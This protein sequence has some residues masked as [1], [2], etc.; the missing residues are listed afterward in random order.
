MIKDINLV[1][2]TLI[3]KEAIEYLLEMERIGGKLLSSEREHKYLT[4]NLVKN[5]WHDGLW[6][7]KEHKLIKCEKVIGG[8]CLVYTI[9]ERGQKVLEIHK[10]ES[11]GV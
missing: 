10:S 2:T 6:C 9:S 1:E 8:T 11:N 4:S 7:C 3:K 5:E